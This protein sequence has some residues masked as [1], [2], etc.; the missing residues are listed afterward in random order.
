MRFLRALKELPTGKTDRSG[1]PNRPKTALRP[2]RYSIAALL[3]LSLALSGAFV[4]AP[5]SQSVESLLKRLES[6]DKQVRDAA[7]TALAK[8]GPGGLDM[9][10]YDSVLFLGPRFQRLNDE[11]KL[12]KDDPVL[13]RILADIGRALAAMGPAAAEELAKRGTSGEI[14]L[15]S[16]LNLGALKTLGPSA[17]KAIPILKAALESENMTAQWSGMLG[18]AFVDGP[19]FPTLRAA[20]RSPKPDLRAMAVRGFGKTA[21]P[22]AVDIVLS[23]LRDPDPVVKEAVFMAM[24]DLGPLLVP[25]IPEL[26]AVENI[27]FRVPFDK[28]GETAV[29]PLKDLL[30]RGQRPICDRAGVALARTGG[31]ALPA[32]TGAL[33]HSNPAV[34][35]AAVS[36]LWNVDG[37]EKFVADS[38]AK[39]WKDKD[40]AVRDAALVSLP[41]IGD[42]GRR[43]VPL[44]MAG[45]KDS[46]APERIR[47]AMALAK[48]GKRAQNS[49][50]VLMVAL[51][52]SEGGVRSAAAQALG[53]VGPDPGVAVPKLVLLA[54]DADAIVRQGAVFALGIMRAGPETQ[55]AVLQAVE[56][57]DPR[58]AS[59]AVRSLWGYESASATAKPILLR[60]LK[61]RLKEIKIAAIDVLS[62]WSKAFPEEAKPILETLRAQDPDQ[63]I[64]DAAAKILRR[65]APA[66][67]N[68]SSGPPPPPPL[69][70][71]PPVPPMFRK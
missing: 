10:F 42:E 44:F 51:A 45:L 39:V 66:P 36:A 5:G 12:P 11:G 67:V 43:L 57:A 6:S 16:E 50:G 21:S 30:L 71:Y 24:G 2:V 22:A 58:V 38:L 33:G 18:L 68:P 20:L 27:E 61:S 15:E 26:L 49:V 25:K 65:F 17:R 63:E 1:P 35:L 34:R 48:L 8:L 41:A 7:V 14:G 13:E 29:P 60:S 4:P 40:A 9:I 32:L 55:K 59:E 70:P 69:P 19:D 46:S 64:K 52:D 47:S 28:M 56:D 23:A 3:T 53:V 37:N 54:K 62:K 31:P